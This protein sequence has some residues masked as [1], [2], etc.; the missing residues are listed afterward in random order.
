MLKNRRL[1]YTDA[2]MVD[3]GNHV[4][5]TEKYKLVK[6]L[7][8]KND[9]FRKENFIE[10]KPAEDEDILLAHTKDYLDKWKNGG[11]SFEEQLRLELPYSRKLFEASLLCVEGTIMASRFALKDMVGLHIGGGFHHA[12][13]D[14]GEGFCVFN[15]IVIAIRRLFMERL[16]KKAM[17][18]DCDLHQGNGTAFMFQGDKDIFTFS[19]HQENNYPFPKIPSGLDVG[20]EDGAGD[21]RYLSELRRHVP[22]ILKAIRPDFAIYVAGADPYKEDQIGKLGLTIEALSERDELIFDMCG[23]YNVPVAVVLAGG[24][25]LKKEDTAKIHYNT[26][27]TGL[28]YAH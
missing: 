23:R 21:E 28:K 5:P 26:I 17:V 18:I 10:P 6:G 3:I 20:L 13:P 12:F 27:K 19:I 4:F 1:V 7:L 2:Y 25:A 22:P 11:F 16:I 9:G 24:Y 14:H 8:V 15:D